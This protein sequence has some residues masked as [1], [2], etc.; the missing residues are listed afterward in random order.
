[1]LTAS[2]RRS[3]TPRSDASPALGAS[4][5]PVAPPKWLF[6]PA[7]CPWG[8]WETV[9]PPHEGRAAEAGARAHTALRPRR[10]PLTQVQLSDSFL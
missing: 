3:D 8:H 2:G 6:F 4:L 10:G 7:A 9:L 1:M 5:G